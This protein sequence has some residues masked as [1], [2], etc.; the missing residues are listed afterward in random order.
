M[1]GGTDPGDRRFLVRVQGVGLGQSRG[2]DLNAVVVRGD[3]G[4]VAVVVV[5]QEDFSPVGVFPEPHPEAVIQLLGLGQ[6]KRCCLLVGHHRAVGGQFLGD[7]DFLVVEQVAGQGLGRA[8]LGTPDGAGHQAARVAALDAPAGAEVA[9]LDVVVFQDLA[10]ELLHVLGADPGGAEPALDLGRLQVAGNNLAQGVDVDGVLGVFGRG[11]LGRGELAAD[12]ARQ[13]LHAADQTAVRVVVDE[14]A[15]CLARRLFA[16]QAEQSSHRIKAD[17]VVLVPADQRGVFRAVRT[18]QRIRWGDDPLGEQV[19]L[20]RRLCVLVEILQREDVGGEGVVAEPAHA[21]VGPALG[22]VVVLWRLGGGAVADFEAVDR[23][24]PGRVGV[25][26]A[27]EFGPQLRHTRGG[28]VVLG[29][30]IEQ[31]HRDVA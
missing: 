21:R 31:G 5:P 10:Q 2:R 30:L 9:D 29:L 26:A 17:L 16:V 7:D 12:V 19:G 1:L 24:E 3:D 22:C 15:Q 13:V 4:V 14:G 6:G 23:A 18:G 27:V 28:E 20:L 8:G 25:V 11:L